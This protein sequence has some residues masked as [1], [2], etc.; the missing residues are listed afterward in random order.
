M[1]R[2]TE[3]QMTGDT[4][5][6]KIE[7]LR[8]VSMESSQTGENSLAEMVAFVESGE[9]VIVTDGQ[10]LVPVQVVEGQ[11]PHLRTFWGGKWTDHL[12]DLPVFF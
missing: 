4:D 3:I 10:F 11:V 7:R 1:I 8:W 5:H 12:L 2:I 9:R 6:A